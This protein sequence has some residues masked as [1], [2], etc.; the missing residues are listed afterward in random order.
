[1]LRQLYGEDGRLAY[2][3]IT[4]PLQGML[5]WLTGCTKRCAVSHRNYFSREKHVQSYIQRIH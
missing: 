3:T 5:R 2:S 4:K 1:L